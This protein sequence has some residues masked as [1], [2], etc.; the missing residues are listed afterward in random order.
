[1]I[2]ILVTYGLSFTVE[3]KNNQTTQIN[4]QSNQ[5]KAEEN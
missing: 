1:M 3:K 5:S 2:S 4:E